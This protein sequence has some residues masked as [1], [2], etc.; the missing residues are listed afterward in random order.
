[1]KI[2]AVEGRIDAALKT[3]DKHTVTFDNLSSAFDVNGKNLSKFITVIENLDKKPI[4]EHIMLQNTLRVTINNLGGEIRIHTFNTTIAFYESIT[5]L[6]N[7]GK[8]DLL[9]ILKDASVV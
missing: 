3:S 1:M 8:A 5:I 9:Q 2:E 7:K 4:L 6:S